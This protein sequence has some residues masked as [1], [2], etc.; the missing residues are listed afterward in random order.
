MLPG[1]ADCLRKSGFGT[2]LRPGAGI[3]DLIG[4]HS[5]GRGGISVG[6]GDPAVGN[7][8][9]S[10]GKRVPSVGIGEILAAGITFF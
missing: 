7:G 1:Q 4:R 5:V 2:L 9:P 10:V 8:G 6:R 3:T